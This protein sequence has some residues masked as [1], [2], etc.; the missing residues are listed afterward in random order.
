[1]AN[2]AEPEYECVMKLPKRTKLK[3][4]KFRIITEQLN[5]EGF[6]RDENGKDVPNGIKFVTF[7]TKMED[8]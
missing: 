8:A 6:S 1:M 7:R 2:M 3:S 4:K 5:W